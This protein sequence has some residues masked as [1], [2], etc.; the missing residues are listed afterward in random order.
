MI[1]ISFE[2]FQKI[3][4][5]VGTIVKV[6]RIPK[7][8]KL[9]KIQ[10][11]LGDRTIQTVGGLVQYYTEEELQD[12]KVIVVTNLA[13]VKLKG[14]ASNGMILCAENADESKVVVLTP[15]KDIENGAKVL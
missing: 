14:E 3:E 6:E 15:E 4:M 12:K 11:D 8:D 10:L 1:E 5:R 2:D 13:P 7:S 9:Y